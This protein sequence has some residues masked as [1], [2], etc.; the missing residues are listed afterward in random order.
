MVPCRTT[1][2]AA[3]SCHAIGDGEGEGRVRERLLGVATTGEQR[4]DALAV[5]RT[6]DD[7][8]TR[9]EGQ[10]LLGQVAVLALVGVGVVDARS[11]HLEEHGAVGGHRRREVDDLEHLGPTE[12]GDLDGTHPST[13]T[14]PVTR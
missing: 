6:A 11:A 14:G 2:S 8:G 9:D 4:D 3:W 10:G 7:L 13:L 5:R 1:A 12:A